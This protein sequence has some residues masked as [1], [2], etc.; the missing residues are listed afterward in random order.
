MSQSDRRDI[1]AMRVVMLAIVVAA[2]LIILAHLAVVIWL[3]WTDGTPGDAKL[4]YTANN[5][6]SVFSDVRTYSVLRDTLGFSLVSLLIALAFGLPAAWLVERTDL[7]GKTLLFTSMAI[8]LL[9]PG[10][11]AAMGW[12]FLLHPRIGLVN[13]LLM[14]SFHLAA[15]PFNI[16][17]IVGMGWVQGL[18][19]APLAF[20]MTAAVFRAMEPSLEE[21]AQIHGGG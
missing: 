2:S 8:G 16:L 21:A 17:S 10:F 1:D 18:N 12:L 4:V 9:I 11:A 13:Q 14:R 3:A 7:R 20:I 6:I 15:P 19:L 5:F